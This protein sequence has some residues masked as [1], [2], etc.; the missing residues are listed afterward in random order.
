MDDLYCSADPSIED[1]LLVKLRAF[2]AVG[3]EKRGDFIHCGLQVSTKL[4]ENGPV[5][6]VLVDQRTYID[7]IVPMAISHSTGSRDKNIQIIG[8]WWGHCSGHGPQRGLIVHTESASF[9]SRVEHQ[10][11]DTHSVCSPTHGPT[12]RAPAKRLP[13]MGEGRGCREQ[14]PTAGSAQRDNPCSI[15]VSHSPPS[16]G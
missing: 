4:D 11:R 8:A 13:H 6:S 14:Y 16:G 9:L 7:K 12:A 10:Q 2:F 1:S 15:E 3:K 5:T